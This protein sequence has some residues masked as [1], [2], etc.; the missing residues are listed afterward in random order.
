MMVPIGA[1]TVRLPTTV[2]TALR[3]A[4]AA[5]GED[6]ITALRLAFPQP[7]SS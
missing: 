6:A 5:E 3:V 7:W 4:T 2:V 1:S